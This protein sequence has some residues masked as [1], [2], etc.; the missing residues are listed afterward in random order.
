MK[1]IKI[2]IE[3]QKLSKKEFAERL[4][5]STQMLYRILSGKSEPA[6]E[7]L[8]RI[9]MYFDVSM[10]YLLEVSDVKKSFGFEDTEAASI[11]EE[12][13]YILY[14][15]YKNLKKRDKGF[16]KEVVTLFLKEEEEK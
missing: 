14:E 12:E 4:N 16:L 15:H 11:A 10:D 3:E 9:A 8:L 13:D 5:I 6:P 2:L 1:R 7:L